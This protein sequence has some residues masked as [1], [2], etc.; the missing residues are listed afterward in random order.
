MNLLQKITFV[1]LEKQKKHILRIDYLRKVSNQPMK[2]EK[3]SF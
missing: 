2:T 1:E 3:D